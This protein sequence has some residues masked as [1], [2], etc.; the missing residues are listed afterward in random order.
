MV[1]VGELGME[2]GRDPSAP[3]HCAQDDMW[4]EGE[5]LGRGG[6]W[7]PASARTRGLGMTGGGNV[8]KIVG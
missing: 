3:L 7:V 2:W 8:V 5:G 4:G 6:G 1:G